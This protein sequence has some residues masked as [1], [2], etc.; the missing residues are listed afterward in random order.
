MRS[1]AVMLRGEEV[2]VEIVK[3]HGFERETNTWPVDW[4]FTDRNFLSTYEEDE[5]VM[6]AIYE[7]L[8]GE[9]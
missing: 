4:R 6:E 7:R 8:R 3:D 1:L 5:I 2:E 9:D